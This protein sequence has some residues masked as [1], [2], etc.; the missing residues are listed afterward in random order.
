M[1]P[2]VATP[3][4]CEC[5][6]E[7][8]VRRRRLPYHPRLAMKHRKQRIGLWMIGACG[9]VGSTVALGVAA[10]RKRLAPTTGLVTELPAFA[11]A[12][13]VDVGEIVIGGHEIRNQT[14]LSAV[15]AMHRDSNVFQAT[16]IKACSAAL[17]RMQRNIRPGIVVGSTRQIRE[18][19]DTGCVRRVSSPATAIKA[20]RQDLSS[21]RDQH[22]LDHVV[23]VN[24]ASSEPPLAHKPAHADYARLSRALKGTGTTI[25]PT[26][27][28]YALG[29]FA[30]DC[31]YI[32]FTPSVG[33]RV[34]AIEEFARDRDVLY[35][36]RDGKTGETLLKSVLAP[37]F[38]MRNLTI[39]SWIGHNIL[40]NRDG[41][42]LDNP[43]VKA[44]KLR[45]KDG[46]L[47]RIVGYPPH[48]QTSIEYVPSLSD[49]K[50]AWDFV[51]FEGFL[52]TKMNLQF[53]WTGSD[54]ILAAPLVIDLVRLTAFEF[55]AG[56][57][58]RMDHLGCFFKDPEG[59][60]DHDLSEQWRLLAAHLVEHG[61]E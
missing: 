54:S 12:D 43:Q 45:T 37:M 6:S 46:L 55:A 23:V 29:A 40:G 33:T 9:G 21:F 59:G 53:V 26:S 24:V 20:I 61:A 47:S 1:R 16:T 8:L 58:G 3:E 60:M 25:L 28:L 27:A 31:S 17:G 35:S 18:M 49:W 5:V 36:G 19:A 7:R 57:R 39:N 41:Q 52:E 14:L 44:S 48:T 10:L 34:A 56:R 13:L 32:N 38:A 51:H 42:V 30:A 22:R 15:R 4:G 2:D 50:I 11:S